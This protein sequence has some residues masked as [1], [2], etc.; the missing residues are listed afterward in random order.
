MSFLSGVLKGVAKV[1]GAAGG[2]MLGG[3]AGAY[4]GYKLGDAVSGG[5]GGGGGGGDAAPS[6]DLNAAATQYGGYATEDRNRFLKA[7]DGGQDALE[8]STKAAV[9]NA[10]PDYMKNLQG[11]REAAI[12]RGA[13]TG[14]LQTSYEGDLS[15]AFDR[16]VSNAVA[17]Q[18]ANMYGQKLS[19]TG[20]LAGQS[21]NTYLDLLAGN[22]DAHQADQN[23]KYGLLGGIVGAAG[24]AAGAY[25]GARH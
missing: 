17:G 22:R 15:S 19:A 21:G 4:A 11:S 18:A 16:N 12:R 6:G 24:Q 25:Y 13:S 5:G 10:L 3:P 8:S 1:G 2:F 14:D 20:Q 7:L 9:A 23:N